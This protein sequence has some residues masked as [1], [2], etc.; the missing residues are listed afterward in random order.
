MKGEGHNWIIRHT[1]HAG[2]SV[3]LCACKGQASIH[4][5]KTRSNTQKETHT[6]YLCKTAT[7]PRYF[8]VIT[9]LNCSVDA[10]VYLRKHNP[11]RKSGESNNNELL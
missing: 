2:S 3:V 11:S 6:Q 5:K 1:N 7:Q 4:N 10:P 9:R 8:F